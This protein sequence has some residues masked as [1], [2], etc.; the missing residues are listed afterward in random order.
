VRRCSEAA[1]AFERLAQIHYLDNA[2]LACLHAAFRTLNLAESAGTS[3]ELARAYGNA[4]VLFG[5]LSMHGTAQAHALR[6]AG[7]R[8][9]G[10]PG[11][12]L[13]LCIRGDW[14][15]LVRSGRVGQG[16][17]GAGEARALA[18][19]I[20]DMRRWDEILFPWAAIPAHQ[21]DFARSTS[22]PSRCTTR[23]SGAA[24]FRCSRG[25]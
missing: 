24:L 21:G 13:H 12:L 11:A 20:G 3:P 6:G 7:R 25:A 5:L 23:Q 16:T 17:R 19:R 4:A 10:Q 18:E 9:S 22:W 15:L 8:R 14:D 1:R 2:K